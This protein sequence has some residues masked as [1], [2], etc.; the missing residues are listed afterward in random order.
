MQVHGQHPVCPCG[1]EHIGHQLG[2]DGV[3][4]LSLAVLPGIAE[5]GHDGGDPGGGG[6]AEG[7]DHDE[8]LHEVVVYRAAGGLDDE[9]IAAADGLVDGDGDL[10][11]GKLLADAVAQ[12]QTQLAGDGLGQGGIGIACEDL[13]FFGVVA[14][15]R[16]TP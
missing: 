3:A 13:D 4:A 11:V 15:V 7:V 6:P 8:Q 1:G 14:H 16:F 9:H 10:P 12:R 5:I 2:A